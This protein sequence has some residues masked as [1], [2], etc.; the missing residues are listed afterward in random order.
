MLWS[1]FNTI[2]IGQIWLNFMPFTNLLI[3]N[4]KFTLDKSSL[5][6]FQLYFLH[7]HVGRRDDASR[8]KSLR[9][10]LSST[11]GALW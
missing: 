11:F 4:L 3:Y 5:Y 2:Y 6:A 8:K 7:D 10:M 1:Q 9:Q